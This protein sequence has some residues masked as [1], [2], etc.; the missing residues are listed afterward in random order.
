MSDIDALKKDVLKILE[1]EGLIKALEKLRYDSSVKLSLPV[2]KYIELKKWLVNEFLHIKNAR[3]EDWKE[4]DIDGVKSILED[5]HLPY[6]LRAEVFKSLLTFYSKAREEVGKI[7]SDVSRRSEASKVVKGLIILIENFSRFVEIKKSEELTFP[8]LI[9]PEPKPNENLLNEIVNIIKNS[10]QII[11]IGPPGTGKTHLAMWVA[12]ILTDE[13][14]RGFWIL[15]QFHKSYRY[16]DFIERIVL[17]SSGKRG[18]VAVEVN[19]EPQLFVRLCRYAQQKKEENIVLVID[20]INRADVASVF[21]ELMYALEYRGYPVRLAYSGEELI[22]P[23]NLYIIATANDIERGTFDIGVALRRRF[24]VIRVDADESKLRELLQSQGA[25]DKVV[26][27]ATRIFNDV[28]NLFEKYIG[29]KGVGH[30]FFRGVKDDTSLAHVWRY[31]I[32]P[33]IEAYLLAPGPLGREAQALIKN[34]ESELSHPPI[35]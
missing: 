17:K 27:L 4:E 16:E 21:G 5:E 14:R 26:S 9:P 34:I 6:D 35:A 10:K 18:E 1:T 12:H 30:L 29:R 31:R 19:I 32:K 11:L 8:R 24:E 22:V 28:N 15:V 25:Q 20:E 13:G 3:I 2:D 23:E 7:I 33:L